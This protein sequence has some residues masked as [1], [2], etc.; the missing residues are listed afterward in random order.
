L[1]WGAGPGFRVEFA[2]EDVKEKRRK[3]LAGLFW[4]A[5][6][7]AAWF[8]A[9]HRLE[10]PL[11]GIT[12]LS[13][14]SWRAAPAEGVASR[15]SRPERITIH[16]LGGSEVEDL[17]REATARSIKAIQTD[18]IRRRGWNDIG[19]HYI[20]DRSGRVWEGRPAAQTGAHAGSAAVNERNIGVLLLGNFDVQTPSD[21]QLES[22][23]RLV[24]ALRS[25]HGITRANVLSH[26][27]VRCGGGLGPTKCPGK[28]LASWIESY[29]RGEVQ[30]ARAPGAPKS[31]APSTG[32][33]SSLEG[34]RS[35]W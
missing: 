27:E 13:R 34:S 24:E 14:S 5:T 25:R 22:C 20:V 35:A 17:D 19:Y 6:L 1:K 7:A 2:A 10:A 29:R 32:P 18:H 30:T 8:W 16:H 31:G 3:V 23:L 4:V 15:M 28:H 12:L 26:N 11:E 33:V 21:P 9:S